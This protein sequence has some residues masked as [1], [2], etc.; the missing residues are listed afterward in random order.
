MKKQIVEIFKY[1]ISGT[2]TTVVN[3]Y[4]LKIFIDFGIYYVLANIISYTISVI[5]NYIL[6]QRYVFLESAR[7]NTTEAKKQF[8]KFLVMRVLSL[9]VDT[10]LFYIAVSIFGFPVYWSRLILTTV[11]ILVTFV[12]NKWFIFIK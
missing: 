1:G 8:L 2:I 4:L 11:M 9:I 10:L 3:L 6:N 12:L 7:G 5:V